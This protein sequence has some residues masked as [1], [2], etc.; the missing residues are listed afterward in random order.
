[1]LPPSFHE[2]GSGAGRVNVQ[3]QLTVHFRRIKFRIDN[4]Y[5]LPLHNITDVPLTSTSD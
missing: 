4:K 5:V 1:M 2:K 3:Y